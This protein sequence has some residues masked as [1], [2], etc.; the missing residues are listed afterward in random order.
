[1]PLNS[2]SFGSSLN[3]LMWFSSVAFRLLLT[4]NRLGAPCFAVVGYMVLCSRSMSLAFRLLSSIGL[5]PVS[6][7]IVSFIDSIGLALAINDSICAFVGIL[8]IFA[9]CV[10]FGICHSIL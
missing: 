2:L 4:F 9:C 7:L 10:Y 6:L 1:V 8:I 3:V 5:K